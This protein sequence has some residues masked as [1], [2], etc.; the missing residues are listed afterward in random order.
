MNKKSILLLLICSLSLGSCMSILT[1]GYVAESDTNKDGGLS[2]TEFLAVQKNKEDKIKEAKQASL[3][4]EAL[5]K[6]E[7]DKM[8]KNKDGL[9]IKEELLEYFK[10]G[11][12]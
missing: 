3:S 2:F 8:D 5:S 6:Q 9:L 10:D 12:Q 4:I 1:A 11:A 7:F